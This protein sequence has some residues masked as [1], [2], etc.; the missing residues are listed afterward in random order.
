MK[1]LLLSFT[2]IVSIISTNAQYR[3]LE[4]YHNP[5][6]VVTIKQ[7]RVNLLP[8]LIGAIVGA[9]IVNIYS[10]DYDYDNSRSII[11]QHYYQNQIEI[12]RLELLQRQAELLEKQHYRRERGFLGFPKRRH[13]YHY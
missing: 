13:R 3:D 7:P 12:Q 2:L 11:R 9:A 6:Q 1:K 10:N 5:N 8:T 4:V